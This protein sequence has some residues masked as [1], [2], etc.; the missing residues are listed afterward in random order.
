M[1]GATTKHL[2]KPRQATPGPEGVVQHHLSLVKNYGEILRGVAGLLIQVGFLKYC[3]VTLMNVGVL[4]TLQVQAELLVIFSSVY[5]GGGG[6]RPGMYAPVSSISWRKLQ[7]PS[8]CLA[9][10]FPWYGKLSIQ[11]V[12]EPQITP[13]LNHYRIRG[14]KSWISAG[15]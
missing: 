12:C 11:A 5:L 15:E 7:S 1:I 9:I 8:S 4:L 13:A 2:K 6:G 3:T 14:R 10:C